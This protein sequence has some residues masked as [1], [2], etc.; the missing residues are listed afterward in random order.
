MVFSDRPYEHGKV[1]IVNEVSTPG[2]AVQ[3]RVHYLFT[4]LPFWKSMILPLILGIIT[5]VVLL[6][7]EPI[8]IALLVLWAVIISVVV[9]VDWR[10][11]KTLR[12]AR[13]RE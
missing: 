7:S 11:S 10:Y 1:L 8:G 13:F 9:V 12:D 2:N 5:F 4:E 3:R 6:F